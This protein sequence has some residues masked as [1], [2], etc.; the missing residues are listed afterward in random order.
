[1]YLC[2]FLACDPMACPIRVFRHADVFS[3]RGT[4][5]T[6]GKGAVKYASYD[7]GTGLLGDLALGLI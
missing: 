2:I 4:T 5:G 1:M 3:V 7:D 6:R